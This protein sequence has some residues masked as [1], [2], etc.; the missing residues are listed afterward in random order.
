VWGSALLIAGTTVGAGV[1][2]LPAVTQDAGFIPAASTLTSCC[3]FSIVT[4]RHQAAN[5]PATPEHH[6]VYDGE[7]GSQS[8]SSHWK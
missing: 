2:A 4:G 1:L 6:T 5:V 8:C 7:E 3:M